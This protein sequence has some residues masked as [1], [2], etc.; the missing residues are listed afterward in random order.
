MTLTTKMLPMPKGKR[1]QLRTKLETHI[2][3]GLDASPGFF[4]SFEDLQEI[5][6]ALAAERAVPT[7]GQMIQTML[8]A[9]DSLCTYT[10]LAVAEACADAALELIARQHKQPPPP[11]TQPA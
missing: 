1:Q 5:A 10:E 11:P 3:L 6:R 4:L 7:R 8:R 2:A 9:R